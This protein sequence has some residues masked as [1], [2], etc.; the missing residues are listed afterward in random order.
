MAVNLAQGVAVTRLAAQD[1]TLLKQVFAAITADSCPTSFNFHMHTVCSDGKLQPEQLIE[2][3][4]AL[5]LKGFAITD[6]HSTNGF[7]RAHQWLAHYETTL[8]ESDHPVEE[9][10]S[11]HLPHLWT[12]IEINALLLDEEVHILGYAF[13]PDHDALQPYMQREITQG[14]QYQAKTVVNAIQA[15]G[16]ISVLAHPARYRRSHHELIPAAASLGINGVETYYAYNNPNP[17]MPSPR[18][19]QEVYELATALG[20]LQTCG[21]DTHGLSLLQRL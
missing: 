12:G 11:P 6:H 21:T 14:E 10:A 5:K 13:D 19:T 4:I 3:A 2:Q 18:Q 15:A 9:P 16:G 8:T 1:A 7:R 20:L 17:W